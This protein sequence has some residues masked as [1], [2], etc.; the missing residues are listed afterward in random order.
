MIGFSKGCTALALIFLL[1]GVATPALSAT[2]QFVDATLAKGVT[3]AVPRSWYF[4]SGGEMV[5]LSTSA[6]AALD[7]SGI[8]TVNMGQ[9]I[10]LVAA[11]PDPNL[12]ASV[13]VTVTS[14]RKST[15]GT[16]ALMHD[17]EIQEIARSL[18]TGI[19]VSQ[20][21]FGTRISQ[22]TP[23]T[24]VK[25]GAHSALFVSY[26]R[27]SKAGDTLV[28]LYKF[29]GAGRLYDVALS[30]RV[31]AQKLNQPIMQRIVQSLVIPD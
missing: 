7:L 5:A 26:V 8:A 11:L 12:Y 25:V 24:K 27:S 29:F 14:M 18:R 22:W 3:V 2:N 1:G 10:L 28:H 6:E 15:A 21:S 13:T 20:R 23:L 31:A 4:L 19:E 30:T 16:V 9:E 17:E